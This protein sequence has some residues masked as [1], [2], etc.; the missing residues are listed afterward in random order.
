MEHLR[1]CSLSHADHFNKKSN[2]L[3]RY[4]KRNLIWICLSPLFFR[5]F[6]PFH[7]FINLSIIPTTTA[8]THDLFLFLLSTSLFPF[9][10]IPI[11][12]PISYSPHILSN[13]FRACFIS[14][15]S[16]YQIL[17]LFLYYLLFFFS[18]SICSQ[19]LYSAVQ[20][21]PVFV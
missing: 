11:Y 19:Y 21:P 18:V 3:M 16:S 9:F 12:L 7:F 5:P 10:S 4:K 20:S 6:R 2:L 8:T 14:P 13:C 1:S 15:F 17:V